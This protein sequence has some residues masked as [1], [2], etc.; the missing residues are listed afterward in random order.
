MA[1]LH[2]LAQRQIV[3]NHHN[4]SVGLTGN[5]GYIS[6]TDNGLYPDDDSRS[7]RR[8]LNFHTMM[9][10]LMT[11]EELKNL[12]TAIGEVLKNSR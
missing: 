2:K 9:V 3:S 6:I 10:P 12:H 11:R 8:D 4:I 1:N 7:H 5:V